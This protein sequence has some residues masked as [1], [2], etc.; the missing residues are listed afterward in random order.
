MRASDLHNVSK[1]VGSVFQ[2]PSTQFFNVD[3]T[4]ELAFGCENIG[5]PRAKIHQR[6]Q[7][8]TDLFGLETLIDR[9]IFDLSG[10][11]KQRIACASIHASSPEIYVMDE[12]TAN[13]DKSSIDRLREI[14]KVLKDSGKTVVISEHQLYYLKGLADRYVYMK[15]G[16]VERSYK[17]SVFERLETETMNMMGGLRSAKLPKFKSALRL[18]NMSGTSQL[19]VDDLKFKRGRKTIVDIPKLSIDRG[20]I[21]AITGEN[22]GAGKSTLIQCLSGMLKHKGTIRFK[23]ELVKSKRMKDKCF[24][25]MQD[26]NSQ[27]FAESV[28]EEVGL[29]VPEE[30]KI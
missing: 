23:E 6:I 27:L 19:T 20:D 26:V 14:I 28:F 22:G 4:S 1:L 8:V 9:N 12:P 25:V 15:D 29:N 7:E 17:A 10:G 18:F 21:L 5:Y 30:K 3:T 11:E 24:V 13:L 16:K 2:N